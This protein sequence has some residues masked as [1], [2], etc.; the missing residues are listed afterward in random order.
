MDKLDPT[1]SIFSCGGTIQ[2]NKQILLQARAGKARKPRKSTRSDT[3]VSKGSGNSLQ[4]QTRAELQGNGK[5]KRPQ[6]PIVSPEAG[7]PQ[8]PSK[9]KAK[10]H[11]KNVCRI[12]QSRDLSGGPNDSRIQ[13]GSSGLPIPPSSAPAQS[14]PSTK[15]SV[16]NFISYAGIARR[17]LKKSDT[18]PIPKVDN[19][20]SYS[21]T[22]SSPSHSKN[23]NNF[24][25]I[26]SSPQ[27]STETLIVADTDD[28][29]FNSEMVD[30][31]LGMM[32]GD[33]TISA[34]QDES[35]ESS[36]TKSIADAADSSGESNGG[37]TLVPEKCE[38]SSSTRATSSMDNHY[39]CALSVNEG[40]EVYDQVPNSQISGE[41]FPDEDHAFYEYGLSTFG[42]SSSIEESSSPIND[43][44]YEHF[45]EIE[46]TESG[47][48]V[49]SPREFHDSSND[50]KPYNCYQQPTYETLL[51]GCMSPFFDGQSNCQMNNP[52]MAHHHNF[53]PSLSQ[54]LRYT[55]DPN[56]SQHSNTLHNQLQSLMIGGQA[57]SA[58]PPMPSRS[59]FISG[60]PND[61]TYEEIIDIVKFG[62]VEQVRIYEGKQAPFC[63][64]SFVEACAAF[65]YYSEVQGK[66]VYIRDRQL[67]FGFGKPTIC[68]QSIYNDVAMGASRNV[69]IGNTDASITRATLQAAFEPYGP[70]DQIRLF[71][72]KNA[73]FVHLCS[74]S[75]AMKALSILPAKPLFSGMRLNYGKDRCGSTLSGNSIQALGLAVMGI[76]LGLGIH[77]LGM[78]SMGFSGNPC[79]MNSV[80]MNPMRTLYLGS[81]HWETTSKDV[82]DVIR[83]GLVEQLIYN[84]S[85]NSAFVTFIDPTVAHEL[86]MR[87]TC[88]VGIVIKGKRAKVGWGRPAPTIPAFVFH[89]VQSGATRTVCEDQV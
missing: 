85:R 4:M 28:D 76:S 26:L 25:R 72:S 1:C 3:L 16:N 87:G 79:G 55:P 63:F 49:Q 10:P 61:T 62:P 86:F 66:S 71:P 47:F 75:S 81:L 42:A 14:P 13:T 53:E 34:G 48:H 52:I 57:N 24:Q 7:S 31:N 6:L 19:V 45:N 64:V 20:S 70:I 35:A 36:E 44:A 56:I 78:M 37:G 80:P 30:E 65:N 32:S 84:P 23:A 29:D 60:F 33:D 59:V 27:D 74:V 12:P 51:D 40:N 67:K 69:Y 83:G 77:G 89:A 58:P 73:A 15:R 17:C 9:P 18:E 54:G 43:W 88:E 22:H 5:Q 41:Y 50:L 11:F 39:L 21:H 82:L 2:D 46:M 68:P 38:S 8:L